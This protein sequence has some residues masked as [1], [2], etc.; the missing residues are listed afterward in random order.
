[1]IIEGVDAVS[2]VRKISGTTKPAEAEVGTIRGDY[3]V[4]SPTAANTEKRAIY[5][6]VHASE[7]PAEAGHEIEHWFSPEEI[8]DYIRVDHLAMFGEI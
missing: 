6:I 2:M 3:S 7:T 5:N 4:D 1:M 8:H